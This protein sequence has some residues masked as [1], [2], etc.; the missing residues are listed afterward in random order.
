MAKFLLKFKLLDLSPGNINTSGGIRM[1]TR[2]GSSTE[3]ADLNSYTARVFKT[4]ERISWC[5]WR[6]EHSVCR[7]E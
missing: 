6:G 3:G 2:E 5:G 7:R 1:R 4:L